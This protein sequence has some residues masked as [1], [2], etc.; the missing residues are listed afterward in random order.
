Q[1]VAYKSSYDRRC[2]PS[3][4]SGGEL[5]DYLQAGPVRSQQQE[6]RAVRLAWSSGSTGAIL[7]QSR[8]GISTW[9]NCRG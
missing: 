2:S 5:Q 9:F 7:T 3:C 6:Q 4:V 8:D 1:D